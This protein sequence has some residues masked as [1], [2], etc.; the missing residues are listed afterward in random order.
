[1]TTFE[2]LGIETKGKTGR[3]YTTCPKCSKDRKKSKVPCLTVNSEPNNNWFKCQHCNFSGN[4]ESYEKYETV[5]IKSRF[6]AETPQIYGVDT[7]NMLLSPKKISVNTA[8]KWLLYEI[9]AWTSKGEKYGQVGFP[10]FYRGSLVNVKFRRLEY[11]IKVID[12][13]GEENYC[14]KNWQMKKED[15]AKVCYW[16]LHL[17]DFQECQDLIISEGE[18]DAMTWDEAGFKNILSVPNGAINENV[19]SID[20]KLDFAKD[21]WVIE[22]VYAK[23]K[24]VFLALDDDGPGIRMREELASIIGKSKCYIITYSGRKDINEVHAGEKKKELQGLGKEGVI[25]CFENAKPF[26]V[27]GIVTFDMMESKLEEL[28]LQGF[29]RG[30]ILGEKE[31][32]NGVDKYISLKRPYLGV[33]TGIPGMGK[34]SFWRWYMTQQS[35]KNGVKWGLFVPD[36]RPEEREI[37]KIAEITCG[38]KW[39]RNKPWSMSEVQR[40]RAKDFVR[41]HFY[42]IKPDY[43]N[44]ELIAKISQGQQ[45]VKS[46][47]ALFY[48]LET[49]KLQYNIFGYCVDA[50]NK[51]DHQKPNG[52]SDEQFVSKQLD[53]VLDFNR[54]LDLFGGIIAHPTKLERIKGS[55]NY[56]PPDLYNVK[57]S[58]AWYE[59][60]DLGL[61]IHR[62]KY[63]KIEI[64]KMGNRPVYKEVRDNTFP[65]QVIVNKIKQAEI[66]EEGDFEMFM[67]WKHAE[68]FV[69]DIPD[70]YKLEANDDFAKT[71]EEKTHKSAKLDTPLL[72]NPKQDEKDDG[73][74]FDDDPDN[75][76]F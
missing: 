70:Y 36:S 62:Q 38:A 23:A 48:Y 42:L 65:T 18:I 40:R 11:D 75:L 47:D 20:D 27:G 4:L 41:E 28:S 61:T 34:T 39:E 44:Q 45:G 17:L 72:D 58:S 63:K 30:L 15:G 64:G 7:V 54:D 46:L 5:R 49:L 69:Y 16:G 43:R 71:V 9:P 76:P 14:S 56:E 37:A 8:K 60:A 74:H 13:K 33:I 32:E 10:Y 52:Q 6:P 50:W 24:R 29:Q 66:G 26:P 31:H 55:R 59:K 12:S 51:I 3:F 73:F 1:M 67:D 2:S 57:G 53:R 35:I 21:P 25:Q 68:T 19:V 22:N